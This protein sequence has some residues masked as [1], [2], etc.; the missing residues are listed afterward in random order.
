MEAAAP[1]SNVK[2]AMTRGPGQPSKYGVRLHERIG[3]A[4]TE[5]ERGEIEAAVPNE[6]PVGRWRNGVA[7]MDVNRI[8]ITS[9]MKRFFHLDDGG[10][11]YLVVARNQE[12]AE[13][14]MRDSGIEFSDPSAPYDDARDALIWIEMG[15][16]DVARRMRCHTESDRGVIPL[17]D[18]ELG[19]WFCSEW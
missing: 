13:Q 11:E 15:T 1:V 18:A 19:D 17:V 5:S 14:I 9:T 8:S 7:V 16:D 12:H 3:L 6:H 4:M 10:A 2:I